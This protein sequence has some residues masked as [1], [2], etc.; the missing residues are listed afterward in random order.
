MKLL[1][2]WRTLSVGGLVGLIFWIIIWNG[3]LT[4]VQYMPRWLELLIFLAPLLYLIRGI[5]HGR[6]STSVHAILISL[7]YATAGIWFAFSPQEEIYGYI[8]IALSACLYL[9]SFMTA[10]LLGKKPEKE[11]VA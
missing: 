11:T 4:P 9:G 3:W 8:M 10:K 1:L 5:F 7:L 2:L 6:V